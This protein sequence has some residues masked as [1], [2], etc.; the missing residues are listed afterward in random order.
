[1]IKNKQVKERAIQLLKIFDQTITDI[2]YI[3]KDTRYFAMIESSDGVEIPLST[4]G[5]G[6]K[7]ALTILNSMM[8]AENGVVL[9]DEFE[10]ALHTS[11]MRQVF[12][13]M[14]EISKQLNI[15]LFLTTHN[16]EAVDKLLESAEDG[17]NDVRIIR[18]KRKG[19]KTY[20][21]LT[22]GKEALEA[23]KEY[24]MELRV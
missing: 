13:F 4:H 5:D 20:A 19:N 10:T 12:E 16:I 7:K 2:R 14:L 21:M 1:M 18:L 15:Q 3:K 6:M 9:I 22:E 11:A 24:K 23:R 17:I 8:D